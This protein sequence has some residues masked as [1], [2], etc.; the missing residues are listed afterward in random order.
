MLS[1]GGQVLDNLWR[2]NGKMPKQFKL[3]DD[4]GLSV[5][6]DGADPVSKWNNTLWRG[7]LADAGMVVG[8]T[9]YL[10]EFGGGNAS[11]LNVRFLD[12]DMGIIPKQPS[13][14]EKSFTVLEGAAYVEMYV[15]LNGKQEPQRFTSYPMLVRGST[16]P[17]GFVPPNKAGGGIP[18]LIPDELVNRGAGHGMELEK[19]G[20]RKWRFHGT[21]TSNWLVAGAPVHLEPG[22][23]LFSGTASD[24]SGKNGGLMQIFRKSGSYVQIT[25]VSKG[26][27]TFE[28]AEAADVRFEL[29]GR[30]AGN[31]ID[32]TATASLIRIGDA[33]GGTANLVG[34]DDGLMIS[35]TTVRE[36]VEVTD[37]GVRYVVTNSWS[38]CFFVYNVAAGT[39]RVDRGGATSVLAS[40]RTD[41]S[42]TRN[43]YYSEK[44]GTDIY[45]SKTYGGEIV[46]PEDGKIGF[47]LPQGEGV[48]HPSI[49]RVL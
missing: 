40:V 42:F 23:Y 1:G 48:I 41:D 8:E 29:L 22:T 9:Y 38:G 5:D 16:R 39:Y 32:L 12:A 7:T 37:G 4:G 10:A 11:N 36:S 20:P 43:D 2:W 3:L 44:A 15:S 45:S 35:T 13:A 33:G 17:A 26:P 30:L 47:V 21:P 27:K 18:E 34:P 28:V 24:P 46:L 49:V 25:P 19:L 31:P 14:F 6:Y